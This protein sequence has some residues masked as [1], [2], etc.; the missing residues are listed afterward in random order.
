MKKFPLKLE[1]SLQFRKDHKAFRQL[2]SQKN[3]V[4]FSSNDYL[5]FA[6]NLQIF[7]DAHIIL[8][9][10]D[11]FHNGGTG[12][13]LLSGN[14]K[15][16]ELAEEKLEAFFNSEAA[17]IYNSGYDANLG[18]FAS[19]PQRGDFILYDE[20]SHA[21]I[22][23]GI[24]LGNAKAFKFL[25]NDLEDLEKRILKIRETSGESL[26]YIVTEA[27]FSMDGDMP[28][29][30]QLAKISE[31][32]G[33]YLVV[34]EAHSIGVVG[35]AGRGLVEDK[36]ISDLVFARLIT[37]GKAL[38]AHGAAILGSRQLKEFLVNF[39]RSL[40]YT[41]S[42]P[43]HSVATILAALNHLESEGPGE[44]AKLQNNIEHF[45]SE[46]DKRDLMSRFISGT[47]A[48][49]SCVVPG[50]EKVKQVAATLQLEG[51]DVKPILSPTVPEGKERLRFCIHSFNS[52]EDLN[53]ILTVLK[54][55]IVS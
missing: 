27:V 6:G 18:F 29:L 34:D 37:F 4:D 10:N 1:K 50:N 33:C 31:E 16:Y 11:L 52:E 13:R 32:Y 28:D 2:G 25:H 15:I 51:Y 26:I 7:E 53:S 49:H 24:N 12:S 40:I 55:E 48:I 8:R 42:L 17:L 36:G 54:S 43:P 9:E 45:N 38:G 23:D 39:S 3:L 22:R 35:E 21:S 19:V 30:L 20:L 5:G 41:T 44:I 46:I 47:S 14:H